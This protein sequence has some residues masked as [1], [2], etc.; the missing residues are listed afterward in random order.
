ML[1]YTPQHVS[2]MGHMFGP[3]TPQGTG[4][5]AVQNVAVR[6]VRLTITSA[7]ELLIKCFR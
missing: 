7:E 1:K 4:F 3:I 6:P 2:C 5:L